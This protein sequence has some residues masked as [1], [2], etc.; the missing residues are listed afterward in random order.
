MKNT[1]VFDENKG[2]NKY[3][4]KHFDVVIDLINGKIV[5]EFD[6]EKQNMN[7]SGYETILNHFDELDNSLETLSIIKKPVDKITVGEFVRIF[8]VNK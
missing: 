2:V 7:I 8:G 4:V 5:A 1:I 6:F 3:T